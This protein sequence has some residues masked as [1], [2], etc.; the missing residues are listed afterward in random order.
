MKQD[1][2]HLR[3]VGEVCTSMRLVHRD[4]FHKA[5]KAGGQSK[6]TKGI[7][8][9]VDEPHQLVESEAEKVGGRVTSDDAARDGGDYDPLHLSLYLAIC[10][11]LIPCMAL[12][13]TILFDYSTRCTCC[14]L[15]QV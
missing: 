9:L 15:V 8:S 2:H 12:A 11:C 4:C 13:V 5:G 7:P 14:A 1:R 3:W 10:F 6:A